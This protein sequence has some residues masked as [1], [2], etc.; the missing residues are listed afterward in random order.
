MMIIGEGNRMKCPVTRFYKRTGPPGT[1]FYGFGDKS[2][3]QH[4]LERLKGCQMKFW[5]FNNESTDTI[6]SGN[7]RN[8]DRFFAKDISQ[9][10]IFLCRLASI[11]FMMESITALLP[12]GSIRKK[13]K[14]A[15]DQIELPNFVI[16][17]LFRWLME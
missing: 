1:Y 8:Y 2:G 14:T 16:F 10:I 17:C 3:G 5:I 6:S 15:A 11:F 12:S 13:S 4:C 7:C 9:R